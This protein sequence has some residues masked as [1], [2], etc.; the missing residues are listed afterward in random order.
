M[1]EGVTGLSK[2]MRMLKIIDD[3]LE[4]AQDIPSEVENNLNNAKKQLQSL[5][6]EQ[7]EL[8]T[9]NV[10]STPAAK[11]SMPSDNPEFLLQQSYA[12]MERLAREQE[13][14]VLQG[15]IKEMQYYFTISEKDGYFP[16]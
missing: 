10:F 3:F 7:V 12:T 1:S 13:N 14:D 15:A 9:S 16:E 2:K 11:H 6:E 8:L 5:E 4:N